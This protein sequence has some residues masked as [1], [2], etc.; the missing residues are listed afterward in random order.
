MREIDSIGLR[1]SAYLSQ[2]ED[3][4]QQT[5]K[6]RQ[7]RVSIFLA[8]SSNSSQQLHEYLSRSGRYELV[9]RTDSAAEILWRVAERKP[10]IVLLC[11]PISGCN[12]AELVGQIR[13]FHPLCGVIVLAASTDNASVLAA[14]ASGARGCL[15]R[16]SE[17]AL[18]RMAIT[19]VSNGGMWLHPDVEQLFYQ[20]AKERASI[21]E[22][23][24]S[25]FDNRSAKLTMDCTLELSPAERAQ[26]V[27]R[28]RA[29]RKFP[30]WQTGG[31]VLLSLVLALLLLQLLGR[32]ISTAVAPE[33]EAPASAGEPHFIWS[34]GKSFRMVEM[35]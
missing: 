24:S 17:P 4:H 3:F 8:D 19:S 22:E 21:C 28:V 31:V 1:M 35:R 14:L 9:G 20:M 13:E 34:G 30:V 16:E 5:E 2:P 23:P 10:Q 7:A 32:M 29:P 18:L 11:L 12:V 33:I 6:N 15:L 26:I 25:I 27:R